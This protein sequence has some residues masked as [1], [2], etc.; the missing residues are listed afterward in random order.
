MRLKHHGISNGIR[1]YD[2]ATMFKKKWTEWIVAGLA[3]ILVASMPKFI[4]WLFSTYF[5]D[6]T[7]LKIINAH[8]V[9]GYGMLPNSYRGL[10]KQGEYICFVMKFCCI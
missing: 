6:F 4:D 7:A 9:M 10:M 5:S 1:W 8:D 2:V 3:T